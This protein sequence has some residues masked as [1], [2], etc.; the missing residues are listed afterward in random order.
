MRNDGTALVRPYLGWS[1]KNGFGEIVAQEKSRESTVLLPKAN[2]NEA[3]PFTSVPPGH[4]EL[5]VMADFQNGL[6]VQAIVRNVEI[7]AAQT[8][9]K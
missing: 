8:G 1:L 4:Y 9:T 5:T 7:A 2:L 3:I 6:P